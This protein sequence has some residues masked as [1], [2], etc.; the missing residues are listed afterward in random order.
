MTVDEANRKFKY[1]AFVWWGKKKAAHHIRHESFEMLDGLFPL[2]L[3]SF[4]VDLFGLF[5]SGLLNLPL[6][7]SETCLDAS[8]PLHLPL[9]LDVDTLGR[10]T[11]LVCHVIIMSSKSGLV[12]HKKVINGQEE[13]SSYT[14]NCFYLGLFLHVLFKKFF[15]ECRAL[16]SLVSWVSL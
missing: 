8:L 12:H 7:L 3:L 14:Q 5:R 13:P 6:P 4:S 16:H 11:R 2:V 15:S 1:D 10:M 9:L